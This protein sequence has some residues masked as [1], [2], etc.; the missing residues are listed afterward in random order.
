MYLFC[1]SPLH[2]CFLIASECVKSIFESMNNTHIPLLKYQVSVQQVHD[3]LDNNRILLHDL[4]H[5]EGKASICLL[6][7][8]CSST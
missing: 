7:Q 2:G 8:Y 6:L 3:I 1:I 4:Y 5:V